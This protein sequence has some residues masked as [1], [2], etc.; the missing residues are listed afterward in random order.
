[1]SEKMQKMDEVLTPRQNHHGFESNFGG[2]RDALLH[3]ICTMAEYL[4]FRSCAWST[5]AYDYF[6]QAF[7]TCV[8]AKLQPRFVAQR[9]LVAIEQE[10]PSDN[11]EDLTRI[12]QGIIEQAEAYRKS[13][14]AVL[15]V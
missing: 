15:I 11:L 6:N 2:S 10:D 4:G 7:E 9:L 8:K 13:G 14:S 12:I 1:M 5:T 3:L